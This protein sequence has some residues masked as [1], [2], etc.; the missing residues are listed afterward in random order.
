MTTAATPA[1]RVSWDVQLIAED[2]AV[3]GWHKR[4]LARRAKLGHA[5]IVRFLSGER[6]TAVTAAKIAKALRQDTERYLI[7]RDRDRM[8]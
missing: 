6:Q 5:T 2:M 1:M 4:E 8:A 7:R 3:K